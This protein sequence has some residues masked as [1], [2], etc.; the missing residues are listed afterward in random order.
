MILQWNVQKISL[1]YVRDLTVKHWTLHDCPL[2]LG[3][4]LLFNRKSKASQ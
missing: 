2:K 3:I 1:P 4:I